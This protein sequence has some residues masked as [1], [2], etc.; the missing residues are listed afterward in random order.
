[1]R[2]SAQRGQEQ[3]VLYVSLRSAG[4]ACVATVANLAVS[5]ASDTP[6]NTGSR[7]LALQAF[8]LHLRQELR[9]LSVSQSGAK[10]L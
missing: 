3:L 6:M 2:Q 8:V 1:V 7:Q 5:Y 4:K 10:A 9:R